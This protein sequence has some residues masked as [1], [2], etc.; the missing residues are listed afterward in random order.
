[1][2]NDFWMILWFLECLIYRITDHTK[3][4]VRQRGISNERG[5][6]LCMRGGRKQHHVIN[7]I[8]KSDDKIA[9]FIDLQS[10]EGKINLRK[11]EEFIGFKYMKTN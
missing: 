2:R 11:G 7:V 9:T 1:M 4:F 6:L 8:K 5:I 10:I 3:G